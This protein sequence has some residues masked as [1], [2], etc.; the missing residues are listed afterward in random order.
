MPFKGGNAGCLVV[1][2]RTPPSENGNWGFRM[3]HVEGNQSQ[4]PSCPK[5]VVVALLMPA[6]RILA[7][8]DCR[9]VGGDSVPL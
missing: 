5:H 8:V 4:G 3:A 6:R 7:L 9:P 1:G 2:I